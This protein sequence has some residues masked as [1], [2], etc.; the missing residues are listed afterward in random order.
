MPRKIKVKRYTLWFNADLSPWRAAV[1]KRLL[2]LAE[3][4][5]CY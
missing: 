2:S 3:F 4:V 5:G 1:L